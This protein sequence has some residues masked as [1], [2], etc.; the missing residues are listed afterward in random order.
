MTMQMPGA[1]VVVGGLAL[2]AT[3]CLQPRRYACTDDEQCRVGERTGSCMVDLGWCAYP[4]A[5][6][7][8]GLRYS[9][10]AS[11]TLSN[12]CVPLAGT[13]SSGGSSDTT[14]SSGDTSSSGGSSG[15]SSTGDASSSSTGIPD[16]ERTCVSG[17]HGTAACDTTGNCVLTC[18]APWQD[19][20]GELANGCEVPVGVAHQCSITGL[21]PVA[22]CWTA[23]CGS[24]DVEG[25]ANFGS[26]YCVDC[27]TCQEPLPGQCQWCNHDDG[28]W[29][30][31]DACS[32]GTDLG[33]VCN[34]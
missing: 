24:S 25:T 22:G 16:C 14:Q 19:C 30:P 18:E 15:S 11:T 34:P 21:D 9:A 12:H 3:A 5:D 8:S 6:C 7:D 1:I 32:C 20:D 28:H 10:L 29:H 2:A 31:M 4:D 33:A 23:Y 17:P 26:Y 13:S 27:V